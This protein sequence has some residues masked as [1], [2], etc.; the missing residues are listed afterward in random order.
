MSRGN[1]VLEAVLDRALPYTSGPEWLKAHVLA[2]RWVLAVAGTH[3][4]TTTS[5]LLAFILDKAGLE[6]GFLIGGIAGDFGVS[7]RLGKPPFFVVEADEYDTAFFDKRAKFVHY[8]PRTAVLNNLEFDHAD[9]YPDLESIRRQFHHL[10]RTVP[11]NG[12]LIVN[13]EDREL[14]A[15]L[16]LGCWTPV[17]RFGCA[18]N[19]PFAVRAVRPDWSD[20]DVQGEGSVVARVRWQLLGAHNAMNALAAMLAARHAGVSLPQAAL[21]LSQ[22]AGVR[23]RLEVRGKVRGVTVYDDFAHHPTAVATTL[24]GLRARVGSERIIAVL[25][26]RSNTMKLG[27]H[28]DTLAGAFAKADRVFLYEP[29]DLGWDLKPVVASIGPRARTAA[30]IEDLAVRLAREAGESDHVLIM[31]NGGFGGLHERLL[32]AL[33]G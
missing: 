9:I 12:A 19:M 13:G 21:A 11:G 32:A 18:A 31:S 15:T 7:A 25:E 20:F 16:K 6:P 27:V 17:V 28:K 22:F 23:R 3:G 5:S 26:P 24:E 14:E 2:D 29:P 30:S 4:K 10:V 8:H 33:R 1:P